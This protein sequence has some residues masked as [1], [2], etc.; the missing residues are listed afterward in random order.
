MTPKYRFCPFCVNIPED[1]NILF[2]YAQPM[3][4]IEK[5]NREI[6]P[7]ILINLKTRIFFMYVMFCN[8]KCVLDFVDTARRSKR[9]A[10]FYN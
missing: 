9:I 4:Y 8:D 6:I 5:Y 7:H 3:M 1:K 10:L 2:V